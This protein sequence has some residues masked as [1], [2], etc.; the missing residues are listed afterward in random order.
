MGLDDIDEC[1]PPPKAECVGSKHAQVLTGKPIEGGGGD[2]KVVGAVKLGDLFGD[3]VVS[4]STP[5]TSL[6]G[7]CGRG[8]PYGLSVKCSTPAEDRSWNTAAPPRPGCHA[9]PF[10]Q[11]GATDQVGDPLDIFFTSTCSTKAP[12]ASAAQEQAEVSDLLD[13]SRPAE[14]ARY[15]DERLFLEAFENQGKGRQMDTWDRPSLAELSKGSSN[16][17]VRARLLKLMNYYDVLGVSRD[18]TREKIRQQYKLKALELHPDR[19]GHDQMPEEAELFK[20]ITKAYE[21]LSDPGERAKYD[22]ELRHSEGEMG[23]EEHWFSHLR[24]Q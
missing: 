17:I 16:N 14:R 23:N 9:S 5:A 6:Q 12:V 7:G 4:D 3:P 24:Q 1:D 18:A 22:E 20:V 11:Q 10:P 2:S 19:V 8:V 21:V 13:F 15:A